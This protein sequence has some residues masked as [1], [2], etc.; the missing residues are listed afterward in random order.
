[1]TNFYYRSINLTVTL[2]TKPSN[3][4]STYTLRETVLFLLCCRAPNHV[5]LGQTPT[6]KVHGQIAAK[7][8]FLVWQIVAHLPHQ[9]AAKTRA[10]RR[11]VNDKQAAQTVASVTVAAA[12]LL[13]LEGHKLLTGVWV[14]P[15]WAAS[16]R[17]K[18]VQLVRK[19]QE[20][21]SLARSGEANTTFQARDDRNYW[22]PLHA[23]YLLSKSIPDIEK[24]HFYFLFLTTPQASGPALIGKASRQCNTPSTPTLWINP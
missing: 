18:C 5:S 13:K 23:C 17:D 24:A 11:S 1:M 7:W 14:H 21:H 4:T 22:N 10:Q 8:N 9:P 6:F 20:T 19:S 2:F 3:E 16:Q 12:V 15:L